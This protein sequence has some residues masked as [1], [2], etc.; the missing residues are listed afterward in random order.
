MRSVNQRQF[1]RQATNQKTSVQKPYWNS[2][3]SSFNKVFNLNL[4]K[5]RKQ[6]PRKEWF[7]YRIPISV[8]GFMS[9]CMK[10]AIVFPCHKSALKIQGYEEKQDMW[11]VQDVSMFPFDSLKWKLIKK[12]HECCMQK[13][14]HPISSDTTRYI[15]TNQFATSKQRKSQ[16]HCPRIRWGCNPLVSLPSP[17]YP[18]FHAKIGKTARCFL[19]KQDSVSKVVEVMEVV[20]VHELFYAIG[21]CSLNESFA[22][23]IP[24]EVFILA[25]KVA[26]L[27]S[28]KY[29]GFHHGFVSCKA[30][31]TLLSNKIAAQNF[32]SSNRKVCKQKVTR[33]L[34]K[35]LSW[36]FQ[37]F[38]MFHDVNKTPKRYIG[39]LLD[40]QFFS[41]WTADVAHERIFASHFTWK[42]YYWQ[43]KF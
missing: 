36:Q 43:K 13:V 7:L 30:H 35:R 1:L 32:H 37:C 2:A 29:L 26:V 14:A 23:I 8:G 15:E 12:S 11:C 25:E 33:L 6:Y 27:T 22:L 21:T 42:I 31:I 5:M 28:K 17:W 41:Q 10:K 4:L 40:H 24:V 3:C 39:R 34:N 38:A 9:I 16:L 18:K 20:N 19:H